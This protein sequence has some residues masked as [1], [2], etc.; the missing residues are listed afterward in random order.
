MKRLLR[1]WHRR[2]YVNCRFCGTE[3]RKHKVTLPSLVGYSYCSKICET[4]RWE[5][6]CAS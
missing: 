1:W 4:R 5:E 2:L 6:W 3:F